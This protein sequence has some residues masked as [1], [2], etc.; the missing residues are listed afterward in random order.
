M[1]KKRAAGVSIVSAAENKIEGFAQDLTRL[2]GKAQN[3]AESWLGQRKAIGE[4]L[5]GI[6]DTATSLLSRLGAADDRKGRRRRQRVAAAVRV[7]P[8]LAKRAGTGKRRTMS[9]EARARISEAQR[10][11]WARLKRAAK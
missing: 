7:A 6:R 9:A 5:T 2:L 8:A 4:R 3:K 11:R 10:K 1:A